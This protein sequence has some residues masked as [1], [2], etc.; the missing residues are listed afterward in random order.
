[1]KQFA[2]LLMLIFYS[3]YS[4][5]QLPDYYVYLVTGDVTITKPGK[6]PLAVKQK[7]LI[8]KND[9]L[10][11]KKGTSVT[12]VDKDASFVVLNAPASWTGSDIVKKG[13]KKPNDGVT[14]KYLQLLYHELLDPTHDFDK[15]K[16]ENIA[17]VRG[18]VSRGDECNNRIFPINGLKTSNNIMAFKWHKTS[19]SSNY[20]LFIYDAQGTALLQQK[21]TDTVVVVDL[22]E[23][24]QAK[25]AKYFWRVMSSDGVCEDE[26]PIYFD[27]LTPENESKQAEAIGG[28]ADQNIEIQ[29]QQIDKL[30]KN[31]FIPFASK[32][33]ATIVKENPDNKA[34]RKSYVA[35]LL[36]Y[37][38]DEEARS[39]WKH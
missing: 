13:T 4:H 23:K 15:F 18:G 26:I 2:F 29:L 7:D 11:L 39:A 25:P 22:K 17:G 1:M 38:F 10:T 3:V 36:T 32:S 34:L 24:I 6:A 19:S 20:S 31:G 37:G 33:Y 14:G 9:I 35:F 27:L 5:C 8:F 21:C 12:L 16:K 28:I 30:E